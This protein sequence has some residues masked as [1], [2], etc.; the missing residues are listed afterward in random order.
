MYILYAFHFLHEIAYNL[1]I[2]TERNSSMTD[3]VHDYKIKRLRAKPVM[4]NAEYQKQKQKMLND[5]NEDHELCWSVTPRYVVARERMA[6]LMMYF[7]VTT[8]MDDA[9]IVTRAIQMRDRLHEEIMLMA[10]SAHESG[11]MNSTNAFSRVIAAAK[12]S[13]KTE[14]YREL[15]SILKE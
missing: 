11:D 2:E 1:F 7:P 6:Q 13:A 10:S 5:I 8:V 14:L 3:A 12:L 9:Q 4:A 15:K